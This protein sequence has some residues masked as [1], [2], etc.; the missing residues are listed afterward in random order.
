MWTIAEKLLDYSRNKKNYPKIALFLFWNRA[1]GGKRMHFTT[2]SCESFIEKLASKN[3]IP[4][5]GGA[6]ALVGAIGIALGSMVGSLTVGKKKYADVEQDI[7]K[8]KEKSNLLQNRL[9]N[10]V[11]QDAIAFEPLSKAYGLP[12]ETEE[13][14]AAKQQVMEKALKEACEVPLEI[15]RVCCEAIVLL[16]EYT[17][18][19]SAIAISD[20]GVGAVCCKSA[21]MGAS[22]NVLINVNSMTD[23]EYAEKTRKEMDSLLLEYTK[24]A[25]AVYE[26]VVK[27]IEGK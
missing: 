18:K 23:K 22:L 11:E 20:A 2:E 14:K 7:L 15:M 26:K 5:G 16:E 24:R 3:P 19:G 25:D 17:E 8:I 13:Q 12:K 21:L 1:R 4:G 10:L 6:S 9:L 27:K